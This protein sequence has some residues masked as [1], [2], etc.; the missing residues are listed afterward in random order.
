MWQFYV[1][2]WAE[3][4]RHRSRRV[5]KLRLVGYL[6][7]QWLLKPM[8]WNEMCFQLIIFSNRTRLNAMSYL[9]WLLNDVLFSSKCVCRNNI[10]NDGVLWIPKV[11]VFVQRSCFAFKLTRKLFVC[12]HLRIFQA[13]HIKLTKRELLLFVNCWRLTDL[14]W[15]LLK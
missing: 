7:S 11:N 12:Y 6:Y 10:L 9:R 13:K 8:Y 1:L 2:S 3:G 15:S 5:F 4:G 14:M